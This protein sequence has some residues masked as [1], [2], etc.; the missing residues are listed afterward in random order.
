MK[1]FRVGENWRNLEKTRA[2]LD[3]AG[4]I[5]S[6]TVVHNPPS[7]KESPCYMALVEMENKSREVMEIVDIGK[8]KIKK[9]ARIKS[10]LRR[11]NVQGTKGL[12]NYGIKCR[13][14]E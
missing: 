11:I 6:Y 5:V 8:E 13:V 10:C 7:G 1:S 12:I 2:L 3:R 9:G 4:K 14:V